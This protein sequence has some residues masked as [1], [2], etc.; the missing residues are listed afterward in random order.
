MEDEY[1]N[2]FDKI[3]HLLMGNSKCIV[4]LITEPKFELSNI[5]KDLLSLVTT[6]GSNDYVIVMVN[7]KNISNNTCLG[8]A[9]KNMFPLSKSQCLNF[10]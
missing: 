9:I 4:E 10:T 1:A 7:T 5:T 2:N 8:Y 3:A 6:Y